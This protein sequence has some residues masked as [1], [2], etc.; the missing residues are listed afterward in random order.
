M[1]KNDISDFV[2]ETVTI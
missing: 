2:T 1:I